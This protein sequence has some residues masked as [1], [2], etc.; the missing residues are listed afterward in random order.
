MG[1]AIVAIPA[2]D[3]YVWRISSEKVPH[4]T[5][6]FL[7]EAE[8]KPVDRISAFLGHAVR[9]A[10]FSP[11]GLSVDHRGILG[12]D[13]ADVLFFKRDR[14]SFK[15]FEEFRGQLLKNNDIRDA[16]D[17]V[18]QFP[19]WQ[20]HLTLGYPET[21]AK[22]DK[23][24]YPGIQWVQFDRIALWTGNYDGPWFRLEYN[25][26][27]AE[28]AMS[29]VADAGQEFVLEHFGVKGMKW[30]VRKVK[31]GAARVGKAIETH[32]N[33][34]FERNANSV[35]TFVRVQN[36]AAEKSNR[37]DIP[38]IN[39]KR[40]YRH[41]NFNQLG[42]NHKLTKQYEKEIFDAFDKRLQESLNREGTN[43]SGTRRY[44]LEGSSHPD[45]PGWAVKVVDVKKAE[46]SA[47]HA[48]VPINV[49]RD[50]K[51]F[52]IGIELVGGSMEQ[53][54]EAGANFL[55]H[56]GVK[57]MRW[58]VRKSTSEVTTESVINKGLRSKTKVKAKGGQGQEAHEDAVKVAAQKQK[59]KKSGTAA[60]S[61]KELQ[62]II[63]RAQL[64]QQA[65]AA[66]A[67]GGKKFVSKLIKDEGQR[68]IQR[69]VNERATAAV[70]NAK[71]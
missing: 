15:R 19:E 9:S 54:I 56:Y 32:A 1:L 18:E 10:D 43:V 52:I 65:K 22:P 6:L 58:G 38:R 49:S 4:C 13:K 11:F 21:P 20:P 63:Q 17:S 40:E 71:S 41:A 45:G 62:D 68:Q 29:S 55:E 33:R 57:G 39:N 46:H 69:E 3:D 70:K 26:D 48:S 16:Y 24:D 36:R 44:E 50:D 66:T 23:R 12:D 34:Q 67:T 59:L 8:D 60:L 53:A 7:G 47:A 27:L 35:G 14:Y 42:S 5:L 25:D 64:E 2:E 51:G 28:V 30:G 31:A 37:V 61:N